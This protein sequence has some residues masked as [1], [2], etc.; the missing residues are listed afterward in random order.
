MFTTTSMTGWGVAIVTILNA[1]LPALGIE[2]EEGALTSVME[3]L[4]NII[5][6]IMMIVGQY[7]RGDLKFG[8][9]RK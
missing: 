4:L 2:F 5:G 9:V 1:I 6:F 3:S 8:L 7:R